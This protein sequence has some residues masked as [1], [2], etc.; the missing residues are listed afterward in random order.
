MTF[1]VICTGIAFAIGMVIWSDIA[2]EL[3]DWHR[4]QDKK[5]REKE[6]RFKLKNKSENLINGGNE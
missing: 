2:E 1:S 6:Y 4:R 3:D 5:R